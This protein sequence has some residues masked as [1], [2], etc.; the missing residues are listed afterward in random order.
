VALEDAAEAKLDLSGPRAHPDH[1]YV[2]AEVGINHNGDLQ[3]A[4]QLIDM[5]ADAGCDAVK[6]QKRTIDLVYDS[7]TL[8]SPR[9]SPWGTTQRDQKNG[10]EFG[11]TEY[12]E[13]D[14]YCRERGIP[15]TASAW[16]IPSLDFIEAFDPPFHKVA[17][18]MVTNLPFL[19]EVAS[20]GRPTIASTGMCDVSDIDLLVDV[21]READTPLGLMHTV[22]TYPSD[23]ATLN[24]QVIN[25]LKARYGVAV[26]YSG[27]EPS[28]SP[29]VVAAALGA[30]FLERHITI[31]RS[32]YGSDQAASLEAAGLRQLV[33]TVRKLPLMLGDG[34][35]AWAP[36]EA[37]VAK[38]LRYWAADA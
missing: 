30:Q 25:T 37:E 23:E 15:W 20:L 17:S 18:A 35:K 27:H 1:V 31:D 10:L 2:I 22:S 9:D 13:I 11:I 28:V 12:Q 24:L 3:L 8:D 34:V 36:G 29:S 19:R 4:K 21:F 7:V 32:M 33:A 6:F 38:K 5:A 16:D 14:I 26:G